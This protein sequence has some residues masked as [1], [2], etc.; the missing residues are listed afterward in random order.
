MDNTIQ[1]V[2]TIIGLITA[3]IT[4]I[5]IARTHHQ[6]LQVNRM[7]FILGLHK[8]YQNDEVLLKIYN[9]IEWNKQD[10]KERMRTDY[11]LHM[12]RFFALFEYYLLLKEKRIISEKEA[13]IYY[14]MLETIVHNEVIIEYF[15]NTL[16][17]HVKNNNLP[18]PYPN[19]TNRIKTK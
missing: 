9:D 11:F 7:N 19:L 14:Y 18:N 10:F 12:E 16:L 8:M 15:N 13:A 17:P 4:V 6:T 1:N 2:A 3:I 5:Y